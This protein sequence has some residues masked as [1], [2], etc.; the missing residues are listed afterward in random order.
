MATFNG[1]QATQDMFEYWYRG[2]AAK[3]WEW[4]N[5]GSQGSWDD[6]R[7]GRTAQDNADREREARL[8]E[9][10]SGFAQ[11]KLDAEVKWRKEQL[12]Q[13]YAQMKQ[14]AKTAAER[15]KLDTWYQQE[16]IKI[17]KLAH[18]LDTQRLGFDYQKHLASLGGPA[19]Y[20]E[21]SNFAL[22][23]SQ[24][25]QVAA[26]MQRLLG[27]QGMPAFIAPSGAPTP[28]NGQSLYGQ[29]G[30]NAP[31]PVYQPPSAYDLGAVQ[32]GAVVPPGPAA[33]Q[34]VVRPVQPGTD[35]NTKRLRAG[36]PVRPDPHGKGRQVTVEGTVAAAVPPPVAPAVANVFAQPLAAQPQTM[37]VAQVA[38]AVSN[39]LGLRA[40]RAQGLVDSS[41]Q[42]GLQGAHK[43]APGSVESMTRDDL[44]LL[45]SGLRGA[46]FSPRNFMELYQRSRPGN[47]ASAFAA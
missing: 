43:L 2:E 35:G 23:A 36:Q 47:S 30:L 26:F 45:A 42:L 29:F 33:T 15:L 9:E 18:E 34:Q 13:Q 22:G 8:F 10:S 1:D 7:S 11:K 41:Y 31:N 46:G 14:T 24:N 27:G 4:E 39:A 12:D 19:D 38:P 25:P 28:L 5:A 44:D 3:R 6:Y 16:Q 40:Q 20:V 32:P 21:A 37:T 17:A